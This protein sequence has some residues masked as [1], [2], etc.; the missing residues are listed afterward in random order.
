[1]KVAINSA[2]LNNGHKT[3]GIGF[4]TKNLLNALKDIPGLEIKEFS[5]LEEVK[6]VDVL[7]FPYFD[8]FNH[9]LR[10]NKKFPAVVTIHDV[11]PLVF[12]AHY[13]PGIKGYVNLQL[14]KLALKK[15]KAIITDSEASKKDIVR[16]LGI[17][18]DNISVIYLSPAE[19]FR[20]VK[21]KN[22]LKKTVGKFNLPE[23][24]VLYSGSVNWNKNLLN[25]TQACIKANVDLIVIGK[26]FENRENLN[27]PER[28]SYKE[29]LEK[30]SQNPLIHIKGFVSDED[31]VGIIN[32]A[33]VVLLPSFY[34]GFGLPIVEAQA[35][36]TPVITSDISSM[37]EVAG[38][39]ALFV[40][41]NNTTQI[42]EAILEILNNKNTYESLKIKG[43]ENV[44]RFSWKKVALETFSVYK[45]ILP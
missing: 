16:F 22:S 39:G 45:Q 18:P 1:M 3:R 27:H 9:T 13:P 36:G 26:D 44:K 4:Y 21:D 38:D 2:P 31:L 30:Y 12:S 28:K 43:F 5:D 10:L 6:D 19:H 29:F 23:K 17:K 42:S 20:V 37:S 34:E 25:L 15:S 14:Q 32:L 40:N 35:C 33:S 41:P 24:F 8:L 7:H 11:I